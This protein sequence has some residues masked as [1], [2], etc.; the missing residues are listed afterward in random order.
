MGSI[1][2][3]KIQF[4]CSVTTLFNHFLND[5]MCFRC[6]KN[7]TE[8]RNKLLERKNAKVMV[9]TCKKKLIL[10]ILSLVLSVSAITSLSFIFSKNSNLNHNQTVAIIEQTD[11]NH[12]D[13]SFEVEPQKKENLQ[14]N[15]EEKKK[16]LTKI[17]K[18]RNKLLNMGITDLTQSDDDALTVYKKANKKAKVKGYLADGAVMTVIEQIGKWYKIESGSINGYVPAKYVITAEKVEDSIIDNKGVSAL[19][20]KESVPVLSKTK[21]GSTAV[22]MGYKDREYP[23]IE[24][25]DNEKYALIERTD[26]I[27]GWVPISDIKIKITAPKGMTSDEF[28]EYQYELELEEQKALESYLELKI[29]STGNQLQDDIINLIAHNESGNYKAARNPKSSGEK[30]ITVGAWQWYGENAHKILRLIC[31]ANTSKAKEILEGA[32]TGKKAREKYKLLYKDIIGNDN[33]ESTK[34]IF[35]N[36]E[37]I[38][39]KELLG[40]DQGVSVQNSKIQDDIQARIK[41]AISTYTLTEDNLTIYFCDLFWQNPT[42][43]RAVIK[44]CI[45]HYKSAK[46]FC[47]ADEALK[48]LHE[49]AMKNSV[50]KKYSKRRQYTYSYCKKLK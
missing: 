49:T 4:N 39:I 21:K 41:V 37:L 46:K 9:F 16:K 27:S 3:I 28:K 7:K 42:N 35:T 10:I 30:T 8:Y 45:S 48:Y 23:I 29:S 18:F 24:F 47:K 31:A 33:W 2:Y 40:S 6:S 32:F 12:P 15:E 44:T 50:F 13:D 11:V 17:K 43:A 34:R 36:A 26:T 22:G 1:F 20:I 38:A 14:K 19:I 25:S 5:I